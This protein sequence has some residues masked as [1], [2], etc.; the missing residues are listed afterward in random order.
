MSKSTRGMEKEETGAISDNAPDA[1][2]IKIQ[3]CED[4]TL[5]LEDFALL[6]KELDA[7]EDLVGDDR[8][9]TLDGYVSV[10]ECTRLEQELAD[11]TVKLIES[12]WSPIT[13]TDMLLASA[14]RSHAVD[15]PVRSSL[16]AHK[17]TREEQIRYLKIRHGFSID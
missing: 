13:H 3:E 4:T 12:D 15:L 16:S 5:T 11:L 6:N 10:Q 17:N 8:C 14:F 1:V 9:D 2:P 7:L